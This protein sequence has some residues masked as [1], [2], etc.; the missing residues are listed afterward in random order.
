MNRNNPIW[1]ASGLRTPFVKENKEYK[2]ISALDLSVA[3]LNKMRNTA[4]VNPDY[5]SWG[6]VI[7]H[8]KHSNIAREAVLNSEL[9]EETVAFT[10]TMACST[11]LLGAI[12]LAAM[13]KDNELAIA[14][15][16]ESMSNVQLGLSDQTSKWLRVLPKVK[17]LLNQFKWLSKIFTFKLYIPPGVNVKTGKSMGEHAEITAQRLHIP[18]T[19]QDTLALK[20]HQN[21]FS[22][23]TN[24]FYNDLIFPA[25][26]VI[27]DLIPRKNTTLEKLTSL[28]PVFDKKSGKGTLTAGNSSLFTDGA[29]GVWLAGEKR[30]DELNTPYKAQ[31]IDWEM[32][33]VTIEEEGI[34]MSPSFAI[35]R[36]LE[37][38]GL[39]Y[40]AIDL[41]EIHEAFAS[42]VLAT[43]TNLEN[44]HHLQKVGSSF[45]FGKF[46]MDKLN[47]NGSSIA[48]GHP[49]GAT[50]A[51]ILSQ[52][53]KQITLLGKHKTAVISICA[54]GGLGTVVLIK[55]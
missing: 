11:S 10:T 13:I 53:I 55:T 50:G 39:T 25:F 9:K 7:P 20:S 28:Q 44:P 8:L 14:G 48:I 12:Q 5:V 34:L 51:R 16:V 26:G 4:Q 47:I 30:I 17:G 42:Q 18:K 54:D 2:D 45:N 40:D 6:S 15:G 41:W 36:L 29:A 23:K 37:R 46:P 43:I 3:V 24:K 35:P 52:T 27:E 49:F 33:G 21:Y 31:L 38:H 22:A 19:S 1:L 32:A